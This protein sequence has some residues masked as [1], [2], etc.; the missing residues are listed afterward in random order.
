VEQAVARILHSVAQG[1]QIGMD[2]LAVPLQDLSLNDYGVDIAGMRGL[3]HGA[4]RS[5]T[6]SP[7]TFTYQSF[8]A[9]KSLG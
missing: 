9:S 3:D 4:D 8:V 6:V 7:R 2:E 5:P 1:A